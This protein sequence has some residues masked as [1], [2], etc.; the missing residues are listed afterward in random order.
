M[1]C[2]R[3]I[4]VGQA[5]ADNHPKLKQF[6]LGRMIQKQAAL[7]LYKKAN[8]LSG[9]CGLREISKFQ[10]VLVGYQIIVIDFHA[11][12]SVIYGGPRDNK[13]IILYK[14]GDHFNVINPE[15]LPSFHGKRFLCQKCK[16][17]VSNYFNPPCSYPC[18]TC[19]RQDCSTK[20]KYALIVTKSVVRLLVTIII[21]RVD[22][23]RVLTCPPYV[24]SRF[25]V[26]HAW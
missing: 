26:K 21:K 25:G 19:L 4:A 23:L 6:K 10:G 22:C 17:H 8:V 16:S 3:A 2:G 13:K 15:K 5:L 20:N 24:T 18:N 7:K 1:C 11:R 9:P 12:N 14:H